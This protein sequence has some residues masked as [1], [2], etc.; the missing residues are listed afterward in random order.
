MTNDGE[1]II[2]KPGEGNY[3]YAGAMGFDLLKVPAY[4]PEQN[5]VIPLEIEKVTTGKVLNTQVV[6]LTKGEKSSVISHPTIK[7]IQFTLE[8]KEIKEECG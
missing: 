8:I 5:L 6:T 1:V 2:L 7:R 4:C 3:A